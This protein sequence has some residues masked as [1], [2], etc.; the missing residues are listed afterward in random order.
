MRPALI[1]ID[2]QNFFKDLTGKVL[3]NIIKLI[4]KCHEKAFPVIF[5]QHHDPLPLSVQA[6]KVNVQIDFGSEEWC[7]VK[8]IMDKVNYE[9]DYI[10]KEKKRFDAFWDTNLKEVLLKNKVDTVIVTGL[11]T[12]M[13]C[14]S[15]ARTAV[16]ND[17]ELLFPSD[18]NATR[19]QEWHDA[20][21]ETIKYAFGTVLLTEEVLK[22]IQ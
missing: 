7:L 9:A 12:N 2:M 16:I 1:V 4:D 8:P 15:T 20:T 18:A 10:I 3:G 13:C 21:L 14:E 22:I 19:H 5:T 17:F 11:L 6:K